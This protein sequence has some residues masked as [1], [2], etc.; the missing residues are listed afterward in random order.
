M[1]WNCIMQDRHVLFSYNYSYW[2]SYYLSHCRGS[3]VCSVRSAQEDH[4][5]K[6]LFYDHICDMVNTH[7]FRFTPT[8]LR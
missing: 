1:G 6:N 3:S 4:Y 5:P 7:A 8:V 2:K